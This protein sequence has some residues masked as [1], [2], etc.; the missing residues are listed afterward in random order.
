MKISITLLTLVLISFN[1]FCQEIGTELQGGILIY[2][3]SGKGLVISKKDLGKWTWE[4][5]KLEC[6]KYSEG[7]YKDWRLP[8]INLFD[9]IYKYFDKVNH[10]SANKGVSPGY[11]WSATSLGYNEII[12]TFSFELK[13]FNQAEECLELNVR[14]I[15]VVNLK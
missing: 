9:L 3:E 2:K 8:D 10:L 12:H 5:A 14:A 13:N 7:G 1:C 6:L 11:Y 15:K 4:R